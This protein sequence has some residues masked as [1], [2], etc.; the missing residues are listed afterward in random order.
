M[1]LDVMN[2]APRAGLPRINEDQL[3]GRTQ[4]H[5]SRIKSPNGWQQ[6]RRHHPDTAA[7]QDDSKYVRHAGYDMSVTAGSLK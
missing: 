5:T 7:P 1:G 4:V 2:C 6:N 3:G